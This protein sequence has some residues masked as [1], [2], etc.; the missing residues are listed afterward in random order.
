MVKKIAMHEDS[1]RR[2][3]PKRNIVQERDCQRRK[4]L[5]NKIALKAYS[6]RRKL[7]EK[8]TVGEED[9]YLGR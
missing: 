2:R 9:S 6:A 7:L 4:L 8:K 3:S 5:V 1:A